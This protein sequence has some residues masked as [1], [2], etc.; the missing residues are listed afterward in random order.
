VVGGTGR[1]TRPTGKAV[2]I[3]PHK[4]A[5]AMLGGGGNG[6]RLRTFEARPPV[7]GEGAERLVGLLA[8]HG[9]ALPLG[10]RPAALK[11]RRDAAVLVLGGLRA[12]DHGAGRLDGRARYS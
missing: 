8:H 7:A 3:L 2:G 10:Q 4:D 6:H 1:V 9:P 11:L 12:V 5:A